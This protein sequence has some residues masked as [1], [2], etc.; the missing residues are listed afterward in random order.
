M[1]ILVTGGAGFIGSHTTVALLEDGHD[2]TIVDNLS[3]SSEAVIERV[4]IITGTEPTF[5][6]LDVRD[7][8]ALVQVLK[9]AQPDAVIHFAGLKAVGD[10]VLHPLKYYSHNLDSTFSLLSAMDETNIRRLVFS[11]SATVY[12]GGQLPPY[13][14]EDGPLQST[15]PYGQTKVILER[16]LEDVGA[17]DQRWSIAILRY[18]NPVGAHPTGLIGEDP[19]GVPN[20]LA[21]FISQVAV[22]H[23]PELIVHGGDYETPD[24]T[25]ERDYIHVVDLAEG[26]VAALNWVTAHSGV[27]AWNLGTGLPT[28]VLGL[29][30][31]FERAT[32][33]PLPYRIGPRREGDL[34]RAWA[35]ASRAGEE[36]GWHAQRDVDS[37]AADAWRWQSQNP[38]GLRSTSGR[39]R[40]TPR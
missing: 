23:L 17:A 22:G 25:A 26:H 34:P 24:G 20:N 5:V 33:N 36:L 12:G 11:S 6:N 21:P 13:A 29:L 28:S 10:S 19:R 14:E 1:K 30:S 16:V 27:R 8:G 40:R 9:T 32:G 7:R 3:N 2:V 38:D 35:D 15:N 37:M 31:A 4:G 18:F 39:Q